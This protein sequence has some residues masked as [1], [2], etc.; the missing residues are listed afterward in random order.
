MWRKA[1][2]VNIH[3]LQLV[4]NFAAWIVLGFKKMDHISEGLRS[5]K[6]LTVSEKILFS[7]LVLVF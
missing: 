1:V 3:K 7:E 6:W 5:L 2:K 4:Q